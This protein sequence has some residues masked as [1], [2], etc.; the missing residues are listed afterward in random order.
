MPTTVAVI[1]IGRRV[2][3][4]LGMLIDAHH[5]LWNYDPEQY[6]WI[7]DQNLRRDFGV[8]DLEQLAT[9]HSIDR[10]VSVQARESVE[11][12][13]WLLNLAQHTDRIAGVVGWLPLAEAGLSEVLERYSDHKHLVG[14]R[15]VIQGLPTTDLWLG[16]AFGR[17]IETITAA[18]YAYDILIF[19]NQ[20]PGAIELVDR[21]PNARF[22]VDHIAKPT[23]EPRAGVM[24]RDWRNAFVE[25]ARRD[26]VWCKWSGVATEVRVPEG[27]E[28]SKSWDA[29]VVQ[30]YFDTAVEA[31]GTRR[32]MFGSDWPVCLSATRYGRWLDATRSMIATLS[33]RE[34][35]A[36]MGGNANEFY[37]LKLEK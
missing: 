7:E 4:L 36:I 20:L 13:D 23:I 19:G 2:V 3:Y 6:A 33:T 32:L 30:P 22:V 10:F 37:Q 12:T 9:E 28:P 25:L 34:Q 35:S 1:L 31:F 15:H 21:H 16:E 14:L 24:D 18:G 11:E 8:S 5:H 17:G 26:N 29:A 27:R